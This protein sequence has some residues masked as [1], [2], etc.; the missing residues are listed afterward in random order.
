[1]I[2]DRPAIEC[3]LCEEAPTEGI[4]GLNVCAAEVLFKSVSVTDGI[5]DEYVSGDKVWNHTDGAAFSIVNTS[6]NNK[7]VDSGFYT[8]EGR[9]VTLSQN[10]MASLPSS[11]TYVL[12]I[13]G[14]NSLYYIE[15]NL[16]AIPMPVW[17]DIKITEKNNA[18]FFIGNLAADEVKV[19][20]KVIDGSQY[21]VDGMQLTVYSSAFEYGENDVSITESLH[22]KVTVEGVAKLEPHFNEGNSTVVYAVLFSLVGAVLIGEAV[23]IAFIILKKEKENGGND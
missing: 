11:G 12:E 5:N 4:F 7:L 16:K 20:G 21:K 6:L 10:Y 14:K 9:R 2:R 23:L 17:Q 13:S 19:N 1:G 8:V 18:V 3:E 15:L 22:A